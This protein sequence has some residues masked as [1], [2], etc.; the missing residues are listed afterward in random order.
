MNINTNGKKLY[1]SDEEID[2]IAGGEKKVFVTKR[3]NGK[4]SHVKAERKKSNTGKHLKK[5]KEEDEEI[6]NFNTEIVLGIN[7]SKEKEKEEKKAKKNKKTNNKKNKHKKRN[8]KKHYEAKKKKPNKLVITI[9]T[10]IVLLIIITIF[11]LMAPIFNIT[12]IEVQGNNKINKEEI[13]SLS[14]LKKGDNIFRFN[15]SIISKIKENAYIE[16]AEIKRNLPGTVIISIK[17]RTVK[18]Q[19]N[20]INGYTYIDKN[21][22]ILEHSSTKSDVPVIA[23][24]KSTENVLLNEKRLQD[25]DLETLNDVSKILD[26][27]KT[28]GKDNII[29]EI[30]VENKHDYILYLE[31]ENKRIHIGDTSNLTNK[32]LYVQ[33][34]LE[35]EQGKSG[36]AY[37]NGDISAG[38]KPYFREE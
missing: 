15:K 9:I 4:E 23:G 13:I 1:F 29:T 10:T 33:R 3:I 11:A 8:N 27:A 6:F 28:I 37:V 14:N 16:S 32:M 22:Y 26:A 7:K 36:T 25:E 24:L 31:S 12:S 19:I 5:D 30:N 34:I 18:Y 38:F 21:G 2:T 17:E 35:G 20:I